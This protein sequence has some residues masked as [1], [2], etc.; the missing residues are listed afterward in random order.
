MSALALWE[1]PVSYGAVGATQAADLMAYPPVGYRPFSGRTRIG[2]G[3]ARWQYAS[4]EVLTWGIQRRAGFRIEV[5]ETPS[6]VTDL[7]YTPVSFDE[8]GEP[9]ASSIVGD[10]GEEVFGPEGYAFVVPGVTALLGVPFG[11]FRVKAPARVVYVIDEPRRKGF[12]YGT[13]AGHPED[14]EEAF[15]VDQT[16]DGSVWLEIRAFSRPASRLWWMVYPVLR[17]SQAYYTRRYFRA[18]SGPLD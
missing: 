18:L 16:D 11:P 6:A 3:A 10:S 9:I 14:G 4:T 7:T 17:I 2:H 15:I 1:R 5:T 13:I 12:A 8:S